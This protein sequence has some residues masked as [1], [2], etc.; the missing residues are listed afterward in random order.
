MGSRLISAIDKICHLMGLVAGMIVV[1]LCFFNAY[2]VIMR[3][4]FNRP[5]HWALDVSE[6]L[7][8]G[9][10]LLGGAYAL[11]VGA[12]AN[13]PLFL[14][15]CS[16]RSQLVLRCIGHGLAAIF[17]CLLIWKGWELAFDNLHAQ[18]SSFSRLPLF[19]SYI[20]IPFGGMLL[21]LQA[22]SKIAGGI[23]AYKPSGST[24]RH[25]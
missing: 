2:A 20:I 15:R 17:G 3:Y 14:D 4:V 1:A 13:I 8:V 11:Q 23:A 6:F 21:L 10:V 12:H 9:T 16:P 19:P 7:L 22:V 25:P 5:P 18:T 24:G